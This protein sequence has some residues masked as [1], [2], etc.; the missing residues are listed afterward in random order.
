[1][2][3]MTGH[4]AVGVGRQVAVD[5]PRAAPST[6]RPSRCRPCRPSSSRRRGSAGSRPARARESRSAVSAMKCTPQKTIASASGR[7]C[8][9]F[10]SWNESPTKS[11]CSH[12]LV[13]LVEVAQHDDAVAERRLR[14]ADAGVELGVGG[15][16]CTPPAA[17]PGGG[18][19]PGRRRR[20]R[21]RGRRRAHR[22]G[23]RR[24]RSPRARGPAPGLQVD[25]AAAPCALA[26]G[27]FA[28]D[29]LD[30]RVDAA[31]GVLLL[32]GSRPGRPVKR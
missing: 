22:R 11:A 24:G 16:A 32:S 12:D 14:G 3:G 21:R 30:C 18:S 19:R 8:A 28:R 23:P 15:A 25:A 13:A 5:A 20:W 10:A 26:G 17:G 27:L 1:M 4:A 9:A 31:H 29:Q 2:T 6:P 7:V